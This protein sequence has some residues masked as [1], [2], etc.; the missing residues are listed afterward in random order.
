MSVTITARLTEVKP[1]IRVITEMSRL[2]LLLCRLIWPERGDGDGGGRNHCPAARLPA[3]SMQALRH[4]GQRFEATIA[5]EACP[6]E[7][8]P[9]RRPSLGCNGQRSAATVCKGGRRNDDEPWNLD[10][11]RGHEQPYGQRSTAGEFTWPGCD[12]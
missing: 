2:S 12:R 8:E 9:S 7:A 4:K 10:K 5:G 11:M 6:E 1:G 3:R